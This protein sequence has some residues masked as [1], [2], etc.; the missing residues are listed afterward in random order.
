MNTGVQ[1]ATL[2]SGR[3]VGCAARAARQTEQAVAFD[4]FVRDKAA[5]WHRESGYYGSDCQ[6][7]IRQHG[8]CWAGCSYAPSAGLKRVRRGGDCL[9]G[10]VYIAHEISLDNWPTHPAPR[11]AFDSAQPHVDH[12]FFGKTLSG[13]CSPIAVLGGCPSGASSVCVSPQ[14]AFRGTWSPSEPVLDCDVRR[15]LDLASPFKRLRFDSSQQHDLRWEHA[16]TFASVSTSSATDLST[17]QYMDASSFFAQADTYT[18]PAFRPSLI[19]V[20]AQ[21]Q[22]CSYSQQIPDTLGNCM[23]SLA[24]HD[25]STVPFGHHLWSRVALE[26]SCQ[27]QLSLDAVLAAC[28]WI[29]HKLQ[30]RRANTP[31]AATLSRLSGVPVHQLR[32]AEQT[33]MGWLHWAPLRNWKNL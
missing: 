18:Q 1:P 6:L 11:G 21:E 3:S 24:F 27:N 13:S 5:S 15:Q 22:S 7:N 10:H 28:L 26:A 12:N 4:E 8:L 29:A 32:K 9:E 17:R 33:V 19:L 25:P 16:P 14:L 23:S 31:G 30:E 20:T 2:L